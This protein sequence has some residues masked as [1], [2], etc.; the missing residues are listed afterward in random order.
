[1]SKLSQDSSSDVRAAVARNETTSAEVLRSMAEDPHHGVR[2][3]VQASQRQRR[4]AADE[5]AE[6]VTE[7]EAELDEQDD[8]RGRGA[9]AA[10]PLAATA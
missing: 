7:R 2:F 8:E 4:R 3:A 9:A 1:M 10:Q 5:R 6:A